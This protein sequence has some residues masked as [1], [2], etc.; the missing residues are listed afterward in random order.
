SMIYLNCFNLFFEEKFDNDLIVIE[1]HHFDQYKSDQEFY[2]HIYINERLNE[3]ED[4]NQ[5]LGNLFAKIIE[6]EYRVDEID[7]IFGDI[8]EENDE[9]VFSYDDYQNYD[10]ESSIFD[11]LD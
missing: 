9:L 10:E 6:N 5:K 8:H 3:C 1:D 7:I 4:I 2:I 11:Y